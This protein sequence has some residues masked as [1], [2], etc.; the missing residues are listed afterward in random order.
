MSAS[1]VPQESNRSPGRVAP[2]PT[3]ALR[4][5]WP[6]TV[7]VA[8]ARRASCPPPARP[9]GLPA[10]TRS[11]SS[12]GGASAHARASSHQARRSRS[13]RPVREASDS[14]ATCSPPRPLTTHSATPSQR[15]AAA[16]SGWWARSQAYL[17]ID[18]SGR[19]GSPVRAGNRSAPRSAA[20]RA[21][22]A[23]P[24]AS[25]QAIA[26]ASGRP[27]RSSSTPVSAM[28]V[29]PTPATGPP[30]AC[31]RAA[32]VAASAASSSRSG[33]SSAPVGTTVQGVRVAPWA[34]S[35][36]SAARTTA[37]LH[38]VVPTSMPTSSSSP[39]T[40][41][42]RRPGRGEAA[43]RL[44]PAAHRTRPGG[45]GDQHRVAAAQPQGAAA[46]LQLA[47][48]VGDDQD[49]EGGLQGGGGVRSQPLGPEERVG[50]GREQ[51]LGPRAHRPPPA[52]QPVQPRRAPAGAVDA[53]QGE[54]EAEPEMALGPAVDGEALPLQQ[55]REVGRLLE[56]DQQDAL[57][58]GVRHPGG[59]EHGVA[60]GH[61]DGVEGGQQ[62]L[63]PLGLDQPGQPTG[64]HVLAEAQVH[65]RVGAVAA[66]DHPGLG[67]AP[68]AAE[69]AAGEVA[70]R[71]AVD[72]QALAGVQQ[73][74]QQRRVV[75]VG[76]G[77]ARP[78]KPSGSEPI[79]SRSVRPSSSRVRPSP[80]DPNAA[81][82]E[83]TQSSGRERPVGSRRA[84][85]QLVDGRPAPVEAGEPVG[86]QRDRLHGAI[87]PGRNAEELPC[88]RASWIGMSAAVSHQFGG[89]KRNP[90]IPEA[91]G[92]GCL[93][94]DVQ[95]VD[96]EGV[97]EQVVVGQRDRHLALGVS[98]GGG[99]RSIGFVISS[100][101]PSCLPNRDGGRRSARPVALCLETVS[102]PA[103]RVR[104]SGG[105]ALSCLRLALPPSLHPAARGSC[106][107]PWVSTSPANRGPLHR[108]SSMA[109]CDRVV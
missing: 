37:A 108:G 3:E 14:S 92:S 81:V 52:A 56:L 100:Q 71:V 5:S 21:A 90:T 97:P 24:R 41:H 38:R 86:G 10:W 109:A 63:D 54:V 20:S 53:A 49:R 60:G 83:P 29:T 58:D 1:A 88:R 47:R 31:S 99:A 57:A 77:V 50:L 105:D 2:A 91:G 17:A 74:D 62:R 45:E 44:E 46:R 25:C 13:S 94:V 59:D 85:A 28:L 64:V 84:A 61:R 89:N 69:V 104:P 55:H 101:P 95:L 23:S 93:Q 73:L 39:L 18:H 16:T 7:R 33:A 15:T 70:V 8:P 79:A 19:T 106:V 6:A 80:A 72:G 11:A 26:G 30:G 98:E 66:D 87:R 103:D 27:W 51:P 12:P 65:D 78:R 4:W 40:G 102:D 67:L 34:T 107:C 22:S 68:R 48:S 36:P 32:A 82:V 75:A 96:G 9:A 43:D 42:R 35:V 76:L